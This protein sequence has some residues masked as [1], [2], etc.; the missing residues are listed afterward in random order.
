MWH[1]NENKEQKSYGS[2]DLCKGIL[3]DCDYIASCLIFNIMG[4]DMR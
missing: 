2:S 4:L 1:D 3:G